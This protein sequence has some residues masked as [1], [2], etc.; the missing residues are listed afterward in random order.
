MRLIL[1]PLFML[2]L[3]VNAAQAQSVMENLPSTTDDEVEVETPAKPAPP[4]AETYT[5]A[6]VNADVTAD[7]ASHARDQA[8]LAA[9]RSA[10]SQLC[11]RLN[12]PDI[13]AKL[14]DDTIAAMVQCFEVQSERLSS[15]RYIGIFTIRFKPAA[16]QKKMSKAIAAAASGDNGAVSSEPTKAV[17]TGT[18]SHITVA[19]QTDSLVA[20][21]GIKRRL[22]AAPQV[23]QV[24]TLD[25]GRG[26]SHIDLSY[27]GSI[28]DLQQALT[29]QG[30]ILR[31]AAMGNWTLTDGSMVP[32]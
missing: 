23:A 22:N 16:V 31:P 25:L 18:I 19:V 8:L 5:I 7:T 24:T 11:G 26:Q 20:W 30:L 21:A 27:A 28:N 2:F 10:F 13:S 1:F 6:D 4:S 9:Q 14:D 32:R 3:T 15:V 12:V 17:P 29:A